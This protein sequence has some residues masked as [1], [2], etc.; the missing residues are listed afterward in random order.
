MWHTG[1]LLTGAGLRVDPG[2]TLGTFLTRLAGALA[3][4]LIAVALKVL[5]NAVVA[6][7]TGRAT[8]AALAVGL[9]WVSDLTLAALSWHFYF[10]LATEVAVAFDEEMITLSSE[11]ASLR[12]LEDPDWA[13]Q[14]ALLRQEGGQLWWGFFQLANLVVF[15]I[16]VAVAICLLGLVS[17]LL[18]ALPLFAI[19]TLLAGRFADIRLERAVTETAPEGRQARHFIQLATHAA[20]AKELRILGLQ[21]ELAGRHSD[22]WALIGRRT[23]RAQLVGMTARIAGQL[24]FALAYVAALLYV[25]N[26]AVEGRQS[27][28]DVILTATLMA[29]VNLQLGRLLTTVNSLDRVHRALE[30]Y[31]WL[32]RSTPR[33][34]GEASPGRPVPQTRAAIEFRDVSFSYPGASAPALANVDLRLAAGTVVALVGENGAGKTTLV[35]LLCGFYTPTQGTIA[36]DQ[37]DLE[38]L[39]SAQWRQ[40]ISALFQDYLQLELVARESIGL[41]DLPQLD[42]P[43]AVAAAIERAGV[44]GVIASLPAG[45]ATRLG[46]GGGDGFELSQGQWQRVALARAHMRAGPRLLVLD[47]PTSALDP[48][49]EQRLLERYRASAEAARARG[50][51][52]L[53]VSHRLSSAQLAD[54]IVVLDRGRVVER[55]HHS[56]LLARGGRYAELYGLQARAYHRPEPEPG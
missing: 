51:I 31:V 38:D 50:G 27:V 33:S 20:P 41:G 47:E 11:H 12:Q 16:Q 7:D 34:G 55:G 4:P 49:A 22:L 48:E 2:R 30:R 56:Q 44:A 10:T 6:H 15:S 40:S 23:D 28:G 43:E 52:T 18:I 42:N 24:V 37:A 13:D 14:L 54:E 5:T 8:V 3:L 46:R 45:L 9:F 35:K 36:V 29:Q 21:D 17:P 39:D 19:P 25:I 26:Q 53:L 1:R 32:R